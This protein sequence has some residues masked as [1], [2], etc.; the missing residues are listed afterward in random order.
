MAA[1]L[2]ALGDL[3]VQGTGIPIGKLA[4]YV[5]AAGINPQREDC[6]SQLLVV[7]GEVAN[8]AAYACAPTILTTPLGSLSIIMS[9]GLNKVE[10]REDY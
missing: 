9:F 5:V 4:M 2:C 10:Y 3:G 1:I 6:N 7:I 8:F